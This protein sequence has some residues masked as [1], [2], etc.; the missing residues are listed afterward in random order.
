MHAKTQ[1]SSNNYTYLKVNPPFT[2]GS[3]YQGMHTMRPG[4]TI[5]YA[6]N[7][8][9]L[10]KRYAR[11]LFGGPPPPLPGRGRF[12]GI[13]ILGGCFGRFTGGTSRGF[14]AGSGALLAAGSLG[15]GGVRLESATGGS[16]ADGFEETVETPGDGAED[17][18][19]EGLR[20]GTSPGGRGMEAGFEDEA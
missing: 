1:L 3:R 5:L 15:P 7:I 13:K 18:E 4:E 11:F 12:L 16:A 14:C 20:A 19:N 10:T 9:L 2:K 8:S 17:C 6:S